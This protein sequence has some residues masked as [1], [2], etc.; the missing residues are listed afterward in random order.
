MNGSY[1]EQGWA[2]AEQRGVGQGAGS[3]GSRGENRLQPSRL[4]QTG[5]AKQCYAR[6]CRGSLGEQSAGEHGPVALVRPLSRQS[7]NG[8]AD[9][10]R[11]VVARTG[12]SRQHWNVEAGRHLSCCSEFWC[13]E[14]AS[15]W[16]G[17]PRRCGAFRGRFCSGSRSTVWVGVSFTVAPVNAEPRQRGLV[18]VGIAGHSRR[19]PRQGS[20][21]RDRSAWD[22]SAKLRRRWPRQPCRVGYGCAGHAEACSTEAV[23][24]CPVDAG[25][26]MRRW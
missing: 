10:T 26:A 12:A 3:Y 2:K 15:L 24:Q 11:R 13:A 17:F 6:P 19:L 7:S 16:N 5:C 23:G 4:A 20:R 14:A 21:V 22:P 8:M 18:G 25:Y 1:A 9:R